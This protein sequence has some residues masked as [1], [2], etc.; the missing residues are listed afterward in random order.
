MEGSIE[1][2]WQRTVPAFLQAVEAALEH[3]A[4]PL[5]LNKKRRTP[6]HFAAAGGHVEVCRLLHEWVALDLRPNW[7]N[8]EDKGKNSALH[9]AA[10]VNIGEFNWSKVKYLLLF[11]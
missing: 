10:E 9:L 3:G 6:L 2:C 5:L 1:G 4:S 8:A 7:I 11:C